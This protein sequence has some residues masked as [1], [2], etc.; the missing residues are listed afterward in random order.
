MLEAREVT[1]SFRSWDGAVTAVKGVTMT[2]AD[3]GEMI[4]TIGANA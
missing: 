4:V 1:K 3:G 2:V